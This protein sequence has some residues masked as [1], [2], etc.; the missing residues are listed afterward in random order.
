MKKILF[1]SNMNC[2]HCVKKISEKLEE[3]KLDFEINLSKKAVIIE[4]NADDVY[5]AKTK[6]QEAGYSVD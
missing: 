4:G 1:V 3:T 5:T 6:I 2:E